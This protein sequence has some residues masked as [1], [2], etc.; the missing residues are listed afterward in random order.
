M[1]KAGDK[2]KAIC[3]KCGLVSTTFKIIEGVLYGVCDKCNKKV[4]IPNL[5]K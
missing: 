5:K 3:D 2:S 1:F 4:S